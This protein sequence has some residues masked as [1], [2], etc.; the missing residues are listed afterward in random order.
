MSSPVA[1]VLRLEVWVVEGA[2]DKFALG[3][4]KTAAA[5]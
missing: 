4:K 3:S 2:D 5:T 1:A